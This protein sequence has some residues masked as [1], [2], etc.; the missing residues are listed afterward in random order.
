MVGTENSLGVVLFLACGCRD[1][2]CR[3]RRLP[4]RLFRF[5]RHQQR[6]GSPRAV[7]RS[8]GYIGPRDP[9]NLGRARCRD[10]PST[11]PG[12]HSTR[13]SSLRMMLCLPFREEGR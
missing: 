10:P 12:W 2:L 6:T 8:A 4:S 13:M 5:R 1:A 3:R 11:R 9:A 7:F